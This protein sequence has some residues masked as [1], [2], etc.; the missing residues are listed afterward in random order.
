MSELRVVLLTPPSVERKGVGRFAG[1]RLLRL[2]LPFAVYVV[3]VQPAVTY[4][5]Y[6]PLGHDTGPLWFVGV[7]LI[8]T[9]A[10]AAWVAAR[11]RVPVAA[12]PLRTGRLVRLVVVV[13]QTT[14]LIRLV[15]P[16]GSEAGFSDLNL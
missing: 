10:Y 6:R 14:F 16:A 2:G 9:L 3:G 15:Y 1:D 4:A 8:F 11:G 12:G 5:L 7:L 13:A